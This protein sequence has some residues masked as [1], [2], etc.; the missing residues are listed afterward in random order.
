M[1]SLCRD[2]NA[3]RKVSGPQIAFKPQWL[4]THGAA[5]AHA[6][7]NDAKPHVPRTGPVCPQAITQALL[8]LHRVR[9]TSCRAQARVVFRKA[10]ARTNPRACVQLFILATLLVRGCPVSSIC[11]RRCEVP[12]LPSGSFMT[13]S[14][15]CPFLALLPSEGAIYACFARDHAMNLAHVSIRVVQYFERHLSHVFCRIDV[16]FLALPVTGED[17]IVQRRF[18]G[19]QQW[20]GRML[21]GR[22]S[23]SISDRRLPPPSGR[24]PQPSYCSAARQLSCY[25]ARDGINSAS[26]NSTIFML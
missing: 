25:T 17:V 1:V 16:E 12:P 22:R 24:A 2:R 8:R 14:A 7:H 4:Q 23:S 15:R 19:G 13:A 5:Y 6:L 3:Q 20:R 11:A 21:R 18:H 9:L 10:C 26:P